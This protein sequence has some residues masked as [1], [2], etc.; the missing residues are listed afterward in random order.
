MKIVCFLCLKKGHFTANCFS[1]IY[2]HLCKR[3]HNTLV[4]TKQNNKMSTAQHSNKEI[5]SNDNINN[6]DDAQ[7]SIIGQGNSSNEIYAAINHIVYPGLKFAM[8]PSAFV[9]FTTDT[10][11]SIIVKGLLNQVLQV[12]CITS[13]TY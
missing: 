11:R 6:C 4:H 9:K 1:K 5:S 10:G 13:R 12:P 3:R 2:C 8:L 7:P